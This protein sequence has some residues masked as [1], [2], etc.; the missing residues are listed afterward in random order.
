VSAVERDAAV[1]TVPDDAHERAESGR[2]A[3]P[4]EIELERAPAHSR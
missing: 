4:P 1:S 2:A 3:A